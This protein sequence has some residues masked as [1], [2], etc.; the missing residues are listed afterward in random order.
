MKKLWEWMDEKGY[1]KELPVMVRNQMLIGY[2]T[3]YLLETG[4]ISFRQFGIWLAI[5][6]KERLSLRDGIVLNGNNHIEVIFDILKEKIEAKDEN[7][8]S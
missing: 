3:Q 8:N 6:I 5:K 4:Q 7:Q 1:A 2:M